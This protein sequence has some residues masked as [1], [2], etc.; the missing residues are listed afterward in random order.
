M[1]RPALLPALKAGRSE[2]FF[3][4]RVGKVRILSKVIAVNGSPR[5]GGNT[6][7]MLKAVLEVCSAAG[8]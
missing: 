6:A 5:E 2:G 3:K 8:A 4:Y 7:H 1:F